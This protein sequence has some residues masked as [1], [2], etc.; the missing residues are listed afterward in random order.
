MR[1]RSEQGGR[2]RVANVP[3][4]SRPTSGRIARPTFP[5]IRPQRE[6]KGLIRGSFGDSVNPS[7]SNLPGYPGS[8]GSIVLL[9]LMGGVA[10]LLWG[11][12]MVHSGILRAFGPDLRLLLARALNNRFTRARCWPRPD[13]PA[14][15]L[16]RDRAD[17]Q[18]VRRRGDRQPG[19]RARDHARR[20]Y[21]HHADRAGAVVQRGGGG[22]CA[23][24]HGPR[25]VPQRPAL[26]IKDLRPGLDRPRPDAAGAAHP[27]RHDG[28]GRECPGCARV[29]QR[30][31]RRSGALHPDRRDRHLAGPFQRRQRAA[32]DV[33][34]LFPVHFAL[35]SVRAR[36]R[37]QSR[38]RHQP[39]DG[40][41]A[42]RQSARA[43]GC[44]SAIWST[45]SS[46]SCWWCR[47]CAR[48]RRPSTPGNPISRRQPRCS[49]SSST[50]R[51]RCCSSACS[52]R[53]RG[54]SSGCCRSGR[55]RPIRRGRAISTRAHWKRPR[56]RS[57]MPR[58]RCCIWA[59]IP[60]PCCARSW[61]R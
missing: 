51:P 41:R 11:L 46:A 44:R 6:Q 40:R 49:T 38:Q 20:Q 43:T 26:R 47:S 60:R 21:R 42:A 36:A 12:H 61:R 34:G 53:C 19:A 7:T 3:V 24:H 30:N 35:R 56:S 18:F 54:C 52:T 45:A 10:L 22:A 23:V 50:L 32:G 48:S 9:D 13:R 29:P 55:K 57:P 8:M 25:R 1:R 28:A 14:P 5:A 39:A 2:S 58:A 15:E 31:H 33:A 17:H 27:A 16:D 59:T 4:R 37:R